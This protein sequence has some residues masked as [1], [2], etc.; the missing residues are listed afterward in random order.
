MGAPT[1]WGVTCETY[2]PPGVS[3]DSVQGQCLCYK[4]DVAVQMLEGLGEAICLAVNDGLNDAV[5]AASFL[6][7]YVGEAAEAGEALFRIGSKILR[8]GAKN[9]DIDVCPGQKYTVVDPDDFQSQAG[10]LAC[11]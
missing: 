10:I 9:C 11:D 4:D 7:P 5:L 6:I 3:L 2:A 8:K 1:G